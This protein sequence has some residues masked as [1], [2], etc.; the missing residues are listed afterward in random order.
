[1]GE[2]FA[3]NAKQTFKTREDLEDY[4]WKALGYCDMETVRVLIDI[5]L[6]HKNIL[7]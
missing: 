6:K 2:L 5:V 7:K 1:M 4:I 3:L